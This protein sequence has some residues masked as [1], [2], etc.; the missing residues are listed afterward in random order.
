LELVCVTALGLAAGSG[1]GAVAEDAPRLSLPIR[2][3]PQKTCF[4]Q[5]LVDVDPSSGAQDYRCGT[6]TYDGHKGT[7]FR[8]LSATAA[9]DGIEVLNSADGTVK[10][11]R[12]G[13]ED[14]FVTA[15]TRDAIAGR[16]CGNG[17]VVDH[18]NGWESQYCH[19]KKGSVKVR[20]GDRVSRGDRLGLVGWSGL[21]QFAHLHLEVRKNG[22]PVDP[23][24]GKSQ[25]EACETEPASGAGLWDEAAARAF[26]YPD[27]VVL[28]A[29]FVAD[30]A[31]VERLEIDDRPPLPVRT[32]DAILYYLRAANLKKGDRASFRLEGPSGLLAEAT[33]DPLDRPKA[34]FRPYVGKKRPDTGW[35]AGTYIGSARI[36]RDGKVIAERQ[37][38]LELQ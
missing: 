36:L 35:P 23:F 16:E 22:T 38:R 19:M 18:G 24:S 6:A 34:V 20:T 9:K 21:T 37:G 13:V 29:G 7:D 17:V 25:T 1:M 5:S 33:L 28:G 15:S 11:V 8:V 26:T 2:C 32:S 31:V 10:G 12:D 4:I 30:P 3:E 27:A 14:A